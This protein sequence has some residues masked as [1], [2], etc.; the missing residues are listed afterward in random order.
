MNNEIAG[1][2]TSDVMGLLEVAAAVAKELNATST[3]AR[4]D[5]SYKKDASWND[6]YT[7]FHSTWW[8][9]ATASQC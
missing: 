6:A 3:I 8:C 2:M 7:V 4:G 1:K 9:S 5:V